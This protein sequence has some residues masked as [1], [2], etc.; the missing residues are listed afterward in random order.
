MADQHE[1][2]FTEIYRAQFNDSVFVFLFVFLFLTIQMHKINNPNN[3][4]AKI[5]LTIT[6]AMVSSLG[7]SVPVNERKIIAAFYTLEVMARG[8]IYFTYCCL[9]GQ[10]HGKYLQQMKPSGYSYHYP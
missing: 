9:L 10:G 8:C 1:D 4:N 5:K 7:I 2:D 3:A 6:A